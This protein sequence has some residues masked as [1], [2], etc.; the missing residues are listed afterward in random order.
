MTSLSAGCAVACGRRLHRMLHAVVLR[1]TPANTPEPNPPARP[2]PDQEAPVTDPTA[3][4]AALGDRVGDSAPSW[5]RCG[6]DD[7]VGGRN[8]LCPEQ[9]LA[10]VRLASEGKVLSLQRPIGDPKGDPVWPGRTPAV[11]TQV[12]DEG[13]W[14]EGG[15]G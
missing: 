13:D 8:C 12:L 2:L 3:T 1:T 15:K 9:V 7:Q 14:D 4:P 6:D 10:A 11:R 5:G